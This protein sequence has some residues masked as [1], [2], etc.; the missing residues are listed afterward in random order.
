[1]KDTLKMI[2]KKKKGDKVIERKQDVTF[3]KALL[4]LR[5]KRNNPTQT[6]AIDPEEGFEFNGKD[7][8]PTKKPKKIDQG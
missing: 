4:R 3:K 1:M 8:V 2:A 6:W 5:S 7:I